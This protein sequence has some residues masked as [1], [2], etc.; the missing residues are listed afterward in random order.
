MTLIRTTKWLPRLSTSTSEILSD[1]P[2]PDVGLTSFAT[3]SLRPRYEISDERAEEKRTPKQEKS[4]QELIYNLSKTECLNNLKRQCGRTSLL[5]KIRVHNFIWRAKRNKAM[6]QSKSHNS[7]DDRWTAMTR[8]AVGRVTKSP[9]DSYPETEK[10]HVAA[11][12]DV[13]HTA[14]QTI[15][16]TVQRP[17]LRITQRGNNILFKEVLTPQKSFSVCFPLEARILRL[18][19]NIQSQSNRENNKASTMKKRRFGQSFV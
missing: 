16:R 7:I 6:T 2:A 11:E 5:Q 13:L 14:R 9:N 19:K 17:W 3:E 15:T 18:G 10:A 12:R 4:I 8:I 1:N